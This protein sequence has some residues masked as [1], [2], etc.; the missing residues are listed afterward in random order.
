MSSL[1]GSRAGSVKMVL[2]RLTPHEYRK[3]KVVSKYFKTRAE[4]VEDIIDAD[5]VHINLCIPENIDSN[6]CQFYIS[7]YL[8]GGIP[9]WDMFLSN[10]LSTIFPLMD[11]LGFEFFPLYLL[12]RILDHD[13]LVRYDIKNLY[14]A[15]YDY[16]PHHPVLGSMLDLLGEHYVKDWVEACGGNVT[17]GKLDRALRSVL[18]VKHFKSTTRRHTCNYCSKLVYYKNKGSYFFDRVLVVPCCGMVLHKTT[19]CVNQFL[20]QRVCPTCRSYYVNGELEEESFAFLHDYFTRLR[21]MKISPFPNA[22]PS[23]LPPISDHMSHEG[24]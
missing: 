21:Y 5:G 13:I 11:F 24:S 20:S 14:K 7:N 22:R 12:N 15:V 9:V 23:E 18:R 6:S 8:E 4:Y 10:D 19:H 3:L 2:V 1:E 16:C 17:P